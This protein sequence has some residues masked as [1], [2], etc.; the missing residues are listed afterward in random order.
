MSQDENNAETVSPELKAITEQAKILEQQKNISDYQAAIISNN[1]KNKIPFDL[2]PS[3][4]TLSSDGD[5]GETTYLSYESLSKSMNSLISKLEKATF[6]DKSKQV[7]FIFYDKEAYSK[8]NT[9]RA[10]IKQLNSTELQIKK[11]IE[12]ATK[13][14]QVTATGDISNLSVTAAAV[15]IYGVV[16]SIAGIASLFKNDLTYKNSEVSFS[17]NDIVASFKSAIVNRKF[18]IYVPSLIPLPI[19]SGTTNTAL[20]KEL[21]D[22]NKLNEPLKALGKKLESRIKEEEIALK[23]D[24]ENEV[25]KNNVEE[26]KKFKTILNGD[27]ESIN[28]I[29]KRLKTQTSGSSELE[30]LLSVEAI[31]DLLNKPNTFSIILEVKGKGGVEHKKGFFTGSKVKFS[32]MAFLSCSVFDASAK[33]IFSSA[34]NTHIPFK[35]FND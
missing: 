32:G 5:F 19:A 14:L 11:H 30:S 18:D 28:D 27:L 33:V 8:I 29:D 13:L 6:Y 16:S 34:D 2:K 20:T 1:L 25:L 26:F 23:K 35:S 31:D 15:S 9:Y 7:T 4:G 21:E 12:D 10:L 17:T 3:T 24:P 22:L